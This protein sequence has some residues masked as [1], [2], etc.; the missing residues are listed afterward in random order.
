MFNE[1]TI[2]LRNDYGESVDVTLTNQAEINRTLA[3]KIRPTSLKISLKEKVWNSDG[4]AEEHIY[5]SNLS[6]TTLEKKKRNRFSESLSKQSFIKQ[7]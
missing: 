5:R 6:S 4:E 3:W 7:R 2:T 1:M